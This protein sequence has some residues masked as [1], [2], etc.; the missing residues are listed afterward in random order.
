MK[1][2]LMLLLDQPPHEEEEWPDYPC[3]N[4]GCAPVP[5][6]VYC[7]KCG[8]PG[9]IEEEHLEFIITDDAPT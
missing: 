2:K 9:L 4:C 8:C 6:G 1:F 3:P 5:A 7:Q